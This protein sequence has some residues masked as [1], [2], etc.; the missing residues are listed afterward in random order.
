MVTRVALVSCVK[1]KRDTSAP[2]RDLYLSPLFR[3]FRRYAESRADSWYILSAEHGVLRPEQVVEPYERTLLAM[4]KRERVSWGRRV[5]QQLLDLLPSDAEI[6]LLAGTRYREEIEPFLRERFSVSVPMEGLRIGEQLRW[7][8][9]QGETTRGRHEHLDRFYEI[10]AQLGKLPGQM[11]PLRELPPRSKMPPR[12]IYFFFEP[13]EFRS[14]NDRIPRVVRVG[15]HAVSTGSKSTLRGR[16]KQH[17]GTRAGGGNHRGSIF[18]LHVGAAL[19]AFEPVATRWPP[20]R[21]HPSSPHHATSASTPH[22][23]SPGPT[24]PSRKHRKSRRKHA[25]TGL[26]FLEKAGSCVTRQRDVPRGANPTTRSHH[27]GSRPDFFRGRTG[28]TIPAHDTTPIGPY[29]HGIQV[30]WLPRA[31]RPNGTEASGPW[32][33]DAR[34]ANSSAP[35]SRAPRG[36]GRS[37]RRSTPSTPRGG[38]VNP[39]LWSP[40]DHSMGWRRLGPREAHLP[41]RQPR[42]GHLRRAPERGAGNGPSI[43]RRSRPTATRIARRRGARRTATTF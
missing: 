17:L 10:I 27:D 4:P 20:S 26:M 13:G 25:P 29:H 31:G 15:T 14:G 3:G 34:D 43:R 6:V 38:R 1:Q 32:C 24:R 30:P 28:T 33:R 36:C 12:G 8:R 21:P 39:E 35:N 37:R 40:S 5:R 42:E 23:R 41:G 2:A 19:L 16:L 22:G 11:R 18:R 9:Q 7:L